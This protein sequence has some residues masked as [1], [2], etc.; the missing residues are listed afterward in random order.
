[1]Q[2]NNQLRKPLKPYPL[3]TP[4]SPAV[5]VTP[6]WVCFLLFLMRL[7]LLFICLFSYLCVW[8]FCL[9][10]CL[11][12]MCV[13]YPEVRGGIRYP[14]TGLTDSYEHVGAGNQTWIL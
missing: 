6:L 10:V 5:R 14:A 13:Q 3:S 11:C 8:V 2:E 9:C 12:A 7:S 4:L 1:M